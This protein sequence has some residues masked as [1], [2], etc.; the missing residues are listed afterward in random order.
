MWANAQRDDRPAEYRWRSL[1]KFRN[2]IFFVPRRKLWLMPTA[3]A[4]Q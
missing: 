2:S 3:G 4:V 1:R